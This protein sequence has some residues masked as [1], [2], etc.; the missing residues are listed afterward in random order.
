[1]RSHVT[2]FREFPGTRDFTTHEDAPPRNKN[3]IIIRVS[4]VRVLPP[5]FRRRKI[6]PA[7]P[8]HDDLAAIRC[9]NA[10]A[11]DAG[12][13]VIGGGGPSCFLQIGVFS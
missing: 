10:A 2:A 7:R 4:Q 6:G 1:M 9:R 5:L 11:A 3:E 13:A 8:G 12:K